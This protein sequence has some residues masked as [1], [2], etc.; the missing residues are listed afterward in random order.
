[1]PSPSIQVALNYQGKPLAVMEI[2]SR[3]QPNKA[4]ECKASYGFTTLEVCFLP[5]PQPHPCSWIR[6]PPHCSEAKPFEPST[7]AF[8]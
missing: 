1:M 7:L 3:W 6:N 8:V 4:L 2:E 5:P